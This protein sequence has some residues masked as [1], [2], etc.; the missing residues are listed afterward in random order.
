MD[1]GKL[2]K[3]S[4]NLPA[5]P[6]DIAALRP[7]DV[8]FLTGVVY[9]AREGIYER[10][11]NKGEALPEG[12][13]DQIHE[14]GLL[15]T[16]IPEAYGG[17]GEERSP[18]TN[19]ILMEELAYGDVTLAIAALAPSSF[20]NA[21]VDQGSEEQKRK[22][23][24]GAISGELLLGIAMTEPGTG[25]DLANVQTR[26][27][28]EGDHYRING[29]K[30]FISNGQICDLC[31]VVAKTDPQA[32]PP[33]RGISLLLVEAEPLR[34]LGRGGTIG[35]ALAIACAYTLYPPFLGPA[36][37]SWSR[38]LDADM[39]RARKEVMKRLPLASASRVKAVARELRSRCQLYE[40]LSA[41]SW[42]AR[43]DDYHE[44]HGGD[45]LTCT[46]ATT[47]G[48]HASYSAEH[49][50]RGTGVVLWMWL[51]C[52]G[53]RKG[54][55]P[56][57]SGPPGAAKQVGGSWVVAPRPASTHPDMSQ[58]AGLAVS[59]SGPLALLVAPGSRTSCAPRTPS[60]ETH[61]SGRQEDW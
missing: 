4:L 45:L 23:L 32:D 1:T 41:L 35:T 28:R 26:A 15:A 16:Q 19:A 10:V 8:A 7:G 24:P 54:Y 2:R 46:D 52:G 14:L 47:R 59:H 44:E 53:Q 42:K 9:T 30:T 48:E 55:G 22:Y 11:L 12:L 3:V 13:L 27:I 49:E 58:A 29:A 5:T 20:A 34:E 36:A 25:S 61:V 43:V 50:A 17:G 38:T 18:I 56:L 33:H 6:E 57:A 60:G 40:N 39:R 21:I 37:R 51:A 31:I